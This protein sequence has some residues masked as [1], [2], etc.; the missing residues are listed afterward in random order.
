M[1]H[2]LVKIIVFLN[3][4]MDIMK[5]HQTI[6]V[7]LVLIFVVLAHSIQLHALIVKYPTYFTLITIHVFKI[8]R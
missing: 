5:R 8:A 4:L 7:I 3:A 2:F 1:E 6:L